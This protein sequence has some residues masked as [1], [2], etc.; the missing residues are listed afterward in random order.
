M[1]IKTLLTC[2]MCLWII[3]GSKY[4]K[5]SIIKVCPKLHKTV[6]LNIYIYLNPTFMINDKDLFVQTNSW[7]K[8]L[9]VCGYFMN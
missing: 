3:V 6:T 1:Y 4:N 5:W 2:I 7:L 9:H 8:Y